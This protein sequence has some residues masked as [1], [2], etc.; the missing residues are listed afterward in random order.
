MA[1]TLELTPQ[2]A[3]AKLKASNQAVLIDVREPEEFAFARIEGSELVPMQSVPAEL[4]RLEALADEKELLVMCHHGVRSLQ[5][6]QW[7]REHE[8]GNCFSVT[9]G[10]D[11]WSRE[12]DPSVPRY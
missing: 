12:V 1:A 8:V 9:G 11:R 6:V 10:I 3:A 7:L 2:E 5:V 4:Q